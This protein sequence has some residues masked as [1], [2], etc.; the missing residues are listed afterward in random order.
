MA[1]RSAAQSDEN[2]PL[3]EA[4]QDFFAELRRRTGGDIRTDRYSRMLYS[5]DASIY[6][7]TPF[8]VVLP[9]HV[10]ELQAAV[11]LSAKFR[12]P[13]LPRAGGSSLAGQAVNEAV[14]LDVSRSLNQVLQIDTEARTVRV[15][16]GVVL[17]ELN[18]QLRP[19][20]LQFGPDP[21]SSNRAGMGGVIGNNATGSHSILYGMAVDHVRAMNVLLSDGSRA[22]FSALD[23]E[24]LEQKKRGSGLESAL[25]RRL[26]SLFDDPDTQ[27]A[28]RAGTPFHWRRCGGYNVDRFVEGPQFLRP[29]PPG[30]NLSNLVCGAEGTLALMTEM[31]LGL[32][33]APRLTGL[34]I[35][36]YHSTYEALASV[37]VI[38]ET[39]PSAVELLDNH[40]M[41]LTR[42]VPEYNRM[43][44]TFVVGNPHCVLI[45]EFYA[46][47]PDE[48]ASKIRGLEVHLRRQ[49]VPCS[50]I[51]AAL[52]PE[53]QQ[54]VWGVRKAGLGLIMSLRGDK[55]PIAFIEDAA[56]PV[57][58]LADYVDQV[59][60]FCGELGVPVSYYAHASAGCIH[61]R[62]IIDVKVASEVEKL[63]KIAQYSASLAAQYGGVITS[64]HGDGRSRSWLIEQFYGAP[65]YQVL[66]EVKRAFDP[67][68]LFNPGNIVDAPSMTEALRYGADYQTIPVQEH[69]SFASDQGFARAVEMCNGAAICRKKIAGTMCPSFMVTQEEEHS[70]R[71]RANALRAALSGRLPHEELTSKRMYEV[72]DLCI[73]CKAC[74][75]ECPSSV[76]MAKIKSE[77]LA[78]Y[79]KRHGMPLRARMM[80]D[81]ARF[82]RWQSGIL[83]P[84]VNTTLALPAVRYL[85]ERALGIT[86]KRTLPPFARE[87]FPAWFSKRGSRPGVHGKVVLFNDTFNSYNYPHVSIAAVRVIEACGFEVVLP[88]HRC[89]G[90][91][92]ISKGLLDQARA[93]AQETVEKLA[94]Y[95][96]QGLPII[97]LEPSCLLTLRDEFFTLLPDDPRVRDIAACAVTFEEWITRLA[98]EQKLPAQLKTSGKALLH[99]HC[100]QK[101]AVGT[102][103][104]KI[105]LAAAGYE[106]TEVD[107][108]CCGMAGSFGYEAEHYDISIKMAERR[109]LPAVR[110]VDE[111]TVIVAA[112][113]SC[114]QQI[115][116]GTGRNALHPA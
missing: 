18:L 11:E 67:H 35:V 112:G 53:H 95:A 17:D 74:K 109:L 79:Y 29:P 94:P 19:L 34:A 105:M 6:Q 33:A 91:P 98:E 59:E 23:A 39:N 73:E 110:S 55:K 46:E 101:A 106:V 83:A 27:A 82:S 107:S 14:V 80:A 10:D 1:S 41:S 24:G 47:T 66:R 88:G 5:T 50:S 3:P 114:R 65:Y 7:A 69:L 111:A 116:H 93:A 45:T 43:L 32:V 51:V 77:F 108:G 44:E 26:A 76:D 61:I 64:E 4:V 37:P 87:S 56:V 102:K 31:T 96:A 36:H 38:L 100:H 62:P 90:R 21:A 68:N 104:S 92:M 8:G 22:T 52:T 99:G 60:S 97:G 84:I 20:G 115:K 85:L 28:I 71:G 63:P 75:S 25:Y 54:N 2:A 57:A 40:A 89:C 49:G 72:M 58:H 81:I 15:E 30:F 48:L 113:V 16:P 70:T 103:P 9:K 42:S 86:S 13:L 78:H 12:V